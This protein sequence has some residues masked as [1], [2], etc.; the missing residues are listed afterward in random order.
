MLAKGLKAVQ[1]IAEAVDSTYHG[2]IRYRFP[3]TVKADQGLGAGVRT[4]SCRAD[5]HPPELMCYEDFD[6]G[7]V[8]VSFNYQQEGEV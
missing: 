3:N 1:M 5:S 7:L 8:A 4:M 2:W 6:G